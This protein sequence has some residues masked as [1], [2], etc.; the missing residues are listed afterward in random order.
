M[1]PTEA[2]LV[3]S[4]HAVRSRKLARARRA[5]DSDA[6]VVAEELEVDHLDRLPELLGTA[7]GEPRLVIAAWR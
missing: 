4:P 3:I 1:A 5:L 7:D 6:I 2:V